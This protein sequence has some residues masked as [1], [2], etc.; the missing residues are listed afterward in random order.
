MKVN[1]GLIVCLMLVGVNMAHEEMF[2]DNSLIHKLVKRQMV[3][4]C[5]GKACTHDSQCCRFHKCFG[6][7]R[8][9]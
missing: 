8:R 2:E 4:T 5:R 1:I 7:C 9:A 3:I 6:V